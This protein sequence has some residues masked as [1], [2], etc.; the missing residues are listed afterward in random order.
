MNLIPNLFTYTNLLLGFLAI[1][2]IGNGRFSLGVWMIFGAALM[3]GADGTIARLTKKMS[4]FGKELDSL[5]DL[6]SFGV[7]PGVLIYQVLYQSTGYWAIPVSTLSIFGGAFR[8]A[9]YNIY[10]APSS[11]AS[12]FTGLPIPGAALTL[13]SFYLYTFRNPEGRLT[14]PIWIGLSVAV[15]FLMVS[16]IPY[17]RMIVMP[18]SK[19]YLLGMSLFF[20]ILLLG[21]VVFKQVKILFPL[22]VIYLL[23]GPVRAVKLLDHALGRG[24][25]AFLHPVDPAHRSPRLKFFKRR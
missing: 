25:G 24:M 11:R 12:S 5:A 16:Q 10:A 17:S 2:A 4:S 23:S 9:R 19:K 22:M 7:A 13:A 14:I 1:I 8:L 18:L 15:F 20:V 6:V 21:V 3:D